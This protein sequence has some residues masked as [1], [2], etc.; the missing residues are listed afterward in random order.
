MV[1]Y[2]VTVQVEGSIAAEWLEW[3]RSH[4]ISDVLATGYFSGHRL[5]RLVHPETEDGHATFN[6]QYLCPS[7]DAY[8]NYQRL[9]A[10]RLQADHSTRYKDQ[11]VA[12]RTLLEEVE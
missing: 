9:E 3:M 2:S 5:Q 1:I 6:I 8:N 11:F 4:H 7:W 12:F 10:P